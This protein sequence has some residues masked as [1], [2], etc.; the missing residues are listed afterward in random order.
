MRAQ[1]GCKFR[2][3]GGLNLRYEGLCV[4]KGREVRLYVAR[5][6]AGLHE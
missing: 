2:F 6:Q 3:G 5:M 1:F 4:M